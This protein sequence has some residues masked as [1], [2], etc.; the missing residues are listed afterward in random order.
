MLSASLNK[1]FPSFLPSTVSST[2]SEGIRTTDPQF[3]CSSALPTELIRKF[4]LASSNTL[5][6]LCY[7]L[8]SCEPASRSCGPRAVELLRVPTSAPNLT[9]KST[10]NE[11]IRT[12]DLQFECRKALPTELIEKFPLATTNRSTLY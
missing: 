7:I 8:P 4:P 3:E 12:T 11:G 9:N 10:S 6:R 1:T 5:Y 2:S